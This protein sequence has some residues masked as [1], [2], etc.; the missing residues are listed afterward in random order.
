MYVCVCVCLCV[1]VCV[2]MCVCVCVC[3]ICMRA[4]IYVCKNVHNMHTRR[5]RLGP[6][7]FEPP[8]N[9]ALLSYKLGDLQE[10]F[11]QATKS[12]QCYPDHADSKELLQTLKEKFT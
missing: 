11:T 4:C 6:H 5:R 1:C 9:S 3:I 7:T 12:L 2:C 10:S 8:Y